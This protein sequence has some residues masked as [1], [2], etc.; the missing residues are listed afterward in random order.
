MVC[1]CVVGVYANTCVVCVY[2]RACVCVCVCLYMPVAPVDLAGCC[3][4]VWDLRH[5]G[6]AGGYESGLKYE[7]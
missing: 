3:L 6:M 4:F 5:G 1:V 7:R 2:T